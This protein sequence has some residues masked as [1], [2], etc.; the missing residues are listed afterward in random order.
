MPEKWWSGRGRTAD[1]SAFQVLLWQLL[2]HADDTFEINGYGR[3]LA[4]KP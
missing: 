2:A 4:R 1:L 3:L